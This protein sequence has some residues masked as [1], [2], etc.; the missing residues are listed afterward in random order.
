MLDKMNLI[1]ADLTTKSADELWQMISSFYMIDEPTLLK[2]LLPFATPSE[3]EKSEI[4]REATS[5]IEDIRADKKAVQ[6][7]DALLL[8]YSL[9]TQEGVLL[10]CLAEA[11][12]R[13]PDSATADALIRDKLTVAD[14]KSH[15]KGSNSVFVNASTWGLMLTGSVCKLDSANSSNPANA[16]SRLVNKLSEPVIRQAMNQAMAIL[17]KQFVLG[18]TI[19][20]ANKNGEFKRKQGY[21]HSFDMLGEAALTAADAKKYADDYMSAI[22]TLGSSSNLS[23][24]SIPSISMKLSALHPRYNVANEDRVMDELFNTMLILAKRAR[25]LNVPITIDAE[26]MDRLELSLKLFEKLFCHPVI[27]GW[28]Q[29]GLVVQTY[30]KRALPVF[31]WLNQ[32]AE[33]QGDIIPVRLVKGAYWDSEVKWSQQA[34]YDSYPVFTRKEATDV[35]YLACARFVLSTEVNKNLFPQFASHNAQTVT[36]IAVMGKESRYE[37]QR[38]HGMG[39]ALYNHVMAK[40]TP[41]VRIYAP[42]G[43]HKDLLPY[44]V[45]RL[46]ENGANSSFVHRLVDARCP[47]ELLTQHPVEQLLSKESLDNKAIPLPPAIY[48]NRKN[49]SG[50]NIDIESESKPFEQQVEAFMDKSWTA[51]P[52]I[53]GRSLFDELE[54]EGVEALNIT[55]PYDRN[56]S[57]GKAIYAQPHNIELAF[58]SAQAAFDSWNQAPYRERAACI[59]KLA[60]LLES[61]LAEFVA[62]CHKEAGKTIHD[63]IDEVREAIDFCHYYAKQDHI[64]EPVI[65]NGFDGKP[66]VS[67]RQ[68]RGVF[69]CISPWNFPLAIFIGPIAAAL[70]AGNT[71]IAKPAEQTSMIAT[72]AAEL[73]AQAGFPTGVFQLLLGTG[74]ELGNVLTSHPAVSGVAFTGSTQ[75]AMK[76]NQSLSARNC[77]PVPLIA[78]TGGLN[79]MIVD[80]TSLPEQVV[81]DTLKS[82]FSSAGQRCSALRILCVQED[83]ADQII[84]VLSGAMDQLV[85]GLPYI[86]KTDVGPVIDAKAKDKLLTHIYNMTTSHKLVKQLTLDDVCKNGDFVAPCAFEIPSVSYLKE[87]QFGPILHI[88]RFKSSQLPKLVEEINAT[89]Y[90]LTLGIH[91]RNETTYRWI[92]KHAKTGNTYINRDQVGAVVGVQPFGGQ[93]LSGTGPKAGGPNYLYRFTQVNNTE[94]VL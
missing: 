37:F 49:S 86:H 88:V 93:G 31:A 41:N 29:F 44:L 23:N 82:A 68:G 9:D 30:S 60:D 91:S 47:V 8:E 38:L 80:S 40:Y 11:L 16:I 43:S 36:S 67:T 35:S 94:V 72:K 61:N 6:M 57:I 45:R 15:L 71:V 5:L 53:N 54:S 42:V 89:G 70:A 69:V 4:K 26:E 84:E 75:T 32:L 27:K 85:V 73:M 76:I 19:K 58:E 21:Q 13:I 10:M 62:L 12:M 59:S 90:G 50:I 78:E 20:E 34:G 3:E 22:E 64:F 7:I 87:E 33:K 2:E 48:P 28:G 77:E 46:L 51:A 24:A 14:W 81:R 74:S 92:E 65:S 56:I 55:A 1:G 18:R 39:E 17:G 52:V 25:E 79:A 63:A 66:M 83:I